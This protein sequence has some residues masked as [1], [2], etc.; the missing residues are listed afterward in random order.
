VMNVIPSTFFLNFL[1]YAASI[2]G[3]F[4]GIIGAVYYVRTKR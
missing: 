4:L 3:L 2:L 1:A